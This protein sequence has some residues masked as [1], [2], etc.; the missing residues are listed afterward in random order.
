MN[1]F[2]RCR[3]VSISFRIRQLKKRLETF[4]VNRKMIKK[5]QSQKNLSSLRSQNKSL[6]LNGL[7]FLHFTAVKMASSA[8]K[9]AGES[10]VRPQ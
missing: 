10:V 6:I 9:R 4:T 1:W 2:S 5:F 7:V 3:T 8:G